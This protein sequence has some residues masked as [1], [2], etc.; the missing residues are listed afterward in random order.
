MY[1]TII[2]I[3]NDHQTDVRKFSPLLL[4]EIPGASK[5]AFYIDQGLK[6]LAKK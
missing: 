3:A 4:S 6:V 5:E 2:H 1:V